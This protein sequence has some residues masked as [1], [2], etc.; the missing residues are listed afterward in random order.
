MGGGQST[1]STGPAVAG[2]EAFHVLRVQESS[3]GAKCGLEAFFD[4]IISVEQVRLNRDD[5]ALRETL[6]AYEDRPVQMTV[7]SSKT[8]RCR[9]V[10]T[11]PNSVW[12][13]QGLL[14]ISTRFCSISGAHE[15]VWHVLDAQPT[16]PAALAGLQSD[17][18]YIIGAE[19]VLHEEN[20][21]YNLVES[22]DGRVMKLYVY[23]SV[24]DSCREVQLSPNSNWGGEGLLGCRIGYGYLHRIPDPT[25]VTPRPTAGPETPREVRHKDFTKADSRGFVDVSLSSIPSGPS[26]PNEQPRQLLAGT[27]IPEYGQAD[28]SLLAQAPEGEQSLPRLPTDGVRG[29]QAAP[30]RQG[31]GTVLS[32]VSPPQNSA[33]PPQPVLDQYAPGVE[34]VR[35]LN[36]A[37]EAATNSP[38]PPITTAV[39]VPPLD[40]YSPL[41]HTPV[42]STPSQP[43]GTRPQPAPLLQV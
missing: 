1:T 15:R 36:F 3:P 16:S 40:E 7:Y 22:C 26:S 43:V 2:E 19:R 33:V 4:F 12:G 13:G 37:T 23:S 10:T 27:A 24:T 39:S 41:A 32:V 38:T 34:T 30:G 20:D 25:T 31:Y 5:E 18:D 35:K 28:A 11:T 9:Y 42:T 8:C 6:A 17:S 14:G 29:D 21:F